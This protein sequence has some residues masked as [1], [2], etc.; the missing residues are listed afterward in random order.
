MICIN[1]RF[2]KASQIRKAEE[3]T[4]SKTVIECIKN[5]N[6]STSTNWAK[7]EEQQLEK[8]IY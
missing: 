5:I 3:K 4:S 2:K 1:K 8:S 7:F 6:K